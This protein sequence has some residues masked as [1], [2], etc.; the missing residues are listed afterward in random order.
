MS[1]ATTGVPAANASVSTMPNDSPPSDGA[2]RRSASRSAWRLRSSETLPRAWTPLSSSST[3]STSSGVAPTI[4]SWTGRCS[5]S[6]SKARSSTGSPLRST[7]WP[8]KTSFS[9][10]PG[11]GRG[12]ATGDPASTCTPLGM[13][14]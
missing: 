13:T 1:D 8:T 10:S 5:R 7:A 4:S 6:A 11:S 3:P 12:F 9:G 2:T 14:R